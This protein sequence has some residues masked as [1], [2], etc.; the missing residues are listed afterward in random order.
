M[1]F[2]FFFAEFLVY[3]LILTK[4]NDIKNEEKPCS[5]CQ[6]KF[7]EQEHILFQKKTLH[8]TSTILTTYVCSFRKPSLYVCIAVIRIYV[9][10]KKICTHKFYYMFT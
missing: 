3:L 10:L 2:L 4:K 6:V 5:T 7:P 8:S 1:V 9:S